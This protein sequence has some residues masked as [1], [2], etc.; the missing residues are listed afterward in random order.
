VGA[1]DS[2]VAEV[3]VGTLTRLGRVRHSVEMPGPRELRKVDLL[4][5]DLSDAITIPRSLHVSSKAHMPEAWLVVGERPVHASWLWFV[6]RYS[7]ILIRSEGEVAGLQTCLDDFVERSGL[8]PPEQLAEQLL[9]LQPILRPLAPLVTAICASPWQIR[10]PTHL[11]S[12]LA[13]S[14]SDLRVRCQELGFH[15]IEHFITG[16]RLLAFEHLSGS[17]RLSTTAARRAVGITNP[18]NMR[19][20]VRRAQRGLRTLRRSA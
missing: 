18:S 10:R 9:M 20:Q 3:T 8:V 7:P 6:K 16:V 5:V 2:A 12:T 14:L 17:G 1:F 13:V 19:R 11:A 15:R 4:I